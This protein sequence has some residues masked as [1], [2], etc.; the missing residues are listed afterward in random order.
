LTEQQ[1]EALDE[2]FERDG[3]SHDSLREF[4]IEQ[5]Y[6]GVVYQ[7]AFE[8]GESWIAFRPEQIKSATGN[9]GTFDPND[10]NILNQ[11]E[12]PGVVT[13]LL[14]RAVDLIA[15][16]DAVTDGSGVAAVRGRAYTVDGEPVIADP[17]T[18]RGVAIR[19]LAEPRRFPLDLVL[20]TFERGGATE[21][22]AQVREQVAELQG[23]VGLVQEPDTR[24]LPEVEPDAFR[25]LLE[26][27][28]PDGVAV[29]VT[30]EGDIRLDGLTDTAA[31]GALTAFADQQGRRIVTSLDADNDPA[32][33][34][35]LRGAGFVPNVG[36]THIDGLTAAWYREAQET[37]LFQ[38]ATPSL[39]ESA[40][41]IS[42]ITDEQRALASEM[43]D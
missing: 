13:R 18:P 12:A 29:G 36:R 20:D 19:S 5:G 21:F 30:P 37:T 6:D 41:D 33:R 27:A 43:L 15:P 38:S 34:R 39:V 23:R 7:N 16:P 10:P 32:L 42:G 31:L 35:A 8:G 3:E 40:D 1:L 22:A 28:T 26:E 11:D 14:Q 24:P 4:L 9:R 25:E 17:D 2:K